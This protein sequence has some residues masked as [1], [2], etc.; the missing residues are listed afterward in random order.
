MTSKFGWEEGD[1]EIVKQPA[2]SAKSY[3][4]AA[5]LLAIVE[6][7]GARH[8]AGDNT[9]IQQAHDALMALGA[10]CHCDETEYQYGEPSLQLMAAI[11]AAV[12][13]DY[14]KEYRDY[15]GKPEQIAARSNR[16]KARRKMHSKPGDGREIDHKD[17]NPMN[18]RPSN[19]HKVS[20]TTNRKKG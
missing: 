2:K 19:L 1:I 14:K 16:N 9:L 15:H 20:R 18:N 10:T 7:A 5:R 3:A 12:K 6:R 17:G 13:R 11:K 8:N 4:E